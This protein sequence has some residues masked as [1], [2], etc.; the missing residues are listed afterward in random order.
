M[1]LGEA[2]VCPRKVIDEMSQEEIQKMLREN[3]I[4]LISDPRM[5]R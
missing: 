5:T 4:R 2:Y 1:F 3:L